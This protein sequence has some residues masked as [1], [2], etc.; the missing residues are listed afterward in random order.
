MSSR[1]ILDTERVPDRPGLLSEILYQ[2]NNKAERPFFTAP[3]W[4]GLR[5]SDSNSGL[6]W[7]ESLFL[8]RN[9]ESP[10]KNSSHYRRK[11][12]EKGSMVTSHD[13]QDLSSELATVK[14]LQFHW[15]KQ[16]KPTIEEEGTFSVGVPR[17]RARS[18]G[19]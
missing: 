14:S 4:A 9:Q 17:D 13:S 6:V 18:M 15:S 12:L 7:V 2:E 16:I 11:K 3:M 8:F 10:G 5:G 19:I 1:P